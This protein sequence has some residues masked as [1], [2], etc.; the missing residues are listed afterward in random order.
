MRAQL[1]YPYA[2]L[3]VRL[4]FSDKATGALTDCLHETGSALFNFEVHAL[5]QR[6]EDLELRRRW[7]LH[8]I[9]DKVKAA[10]ILSLPRRGGWRLIVINLYG[11]GEAP[12]RQ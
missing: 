4:F 6:Q 8:R 11:E 7:C 1:T 2:T 12:P 5:D 3:V 9:I 10:K